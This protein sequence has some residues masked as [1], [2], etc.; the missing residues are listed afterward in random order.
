MASDVVF[1]VEGL[2]STKATLDT[3]LVTV[4]AGQSLKIDVQG[5]LYDIG[6]LRGA[7]SGAIA[8][9]IT[10]DDTSY[11]YL[12]STGTLVINTTGFPTDETFILLARVMAANGEIGAIYNEKI[13]L[14]SSSSSIGT[15]VIS[16]PVDGDIRGGSTSASSNNDFAA[17]R[18]D[19][20]SDGWNRINRKPPG[21]YTSGDLKFRFYYSWP[22]AVG[23]NKET[24]WKLE[25]AFRN[26]SDAL[27]TWDDNDTQVFDVSSEAADTLYYKELT[28]PSGDFDIDA[29]LMFLKITRMGADAQDDCPENCYVHQQELIYT[30]RQLAGQAGQ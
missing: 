15:C 5:F 11:V 25:Y 9:S 13:L 1:E 30:G 19:A 22:N 20:G 12:D 18:F 2:V 23:N 8:Q 26:S 24:K 7:Y 29:D 16:Y 4:S 27:G 6:G 10:D 21:N 17:I 3:G 14:A 28:L